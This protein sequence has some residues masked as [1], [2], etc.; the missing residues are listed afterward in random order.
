LKAD[1]KE[2]PQKAEKEGGEKK[3]AQTYTI[4]RS[5]QK[6]SLS[7]KERG[8]KKKEYSRSGKKMLGKLKIPY[9]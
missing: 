2:K 7:P 6:K 8:K 3:P 9:E 5:A 1:G 4:S